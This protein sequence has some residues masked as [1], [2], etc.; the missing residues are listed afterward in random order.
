MKTLCHQ[1]A[2]LIPSN[3]KP[4]K[5]KYMVAQQ[6]QLDL[7][8][9]YIKH[10]RERIDKLKRQKEEAVRSNQTDKMFNIESKLP[11]LELRDLGS[12]I[13]V[14]LVSGLNNKTFML[15]EVISVLEEEG[16]EVVNASFSTVGDKIFY[17][18]HAQVK[19]SRLGVETARVYERLQEFIAPLESCWEDV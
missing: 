8:A 19:I 9:R 7:A 4:S 17:T 11:V 10:M 6:D 14:M 16:A 13:Q 5:S 1:L 12:G 18:V 15:Y 3:H 2:S